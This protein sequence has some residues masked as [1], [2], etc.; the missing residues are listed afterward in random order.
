MDDWNR[1]YVRNKT[2]YFNGFELN[3][4][5]VIVLFASQLS[6]NMFVSKLEVTGGIN[7]TKVSLWV[8]GS[9]FEIIAS[10]AQKRTFQFLTIE[11]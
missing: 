5:H 11:Y 3:F 7:A 1:I 9:I 4:L 2:Y 6:R 10:A 8:S